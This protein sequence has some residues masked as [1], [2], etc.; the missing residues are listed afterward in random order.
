MGFV[1]HFSQMIKIQL[2]INLGGG[3]A[4]MTEQRLDVHQIGPGVQQVGGVS[5]ALFV[6]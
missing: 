4:L 2:G 6:G 5:M 3:D 1:V